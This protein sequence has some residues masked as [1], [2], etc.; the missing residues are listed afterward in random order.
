[1]LAARITGNESP[2]STRHV[3]QSKL[4]VCA[5]FICLLN[6]Q[7]FFYDVNKESLMAN[8]AFLA[9][10][11]VLIVSGLIGLSRAL[12]NIWCGPEHH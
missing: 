4:L 12:L 1:M 7:A 10:F 2:G 3:Y 6:R 8:V 11:F 5:N 9:G